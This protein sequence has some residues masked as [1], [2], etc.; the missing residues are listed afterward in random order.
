MRRL[1][2]AMAMRAPTWPRVASPGSRSSILELRGS[3]TTIVSTV[4]SSTPKTTSPSRALI[5]SSTGA[6]KAVGR[7]SVRSAALALIRILTSMSLIRKAT[8]GLADS[9]RSSRLRQSGTRR[10]PRCEEDG[11][12]RRSPTRPA[13]GAGHDL[14]VEHGPHLHGDPGDGEQSTFLRAPAP[15]RGRPHWRWADLSAPLGRSAIRRHGRVDRSGWAAALWTRSRRRAVVSDHGPAGDAG[16]RLSGQIVLGRPDS[17]AED[18]GV[19]TLEGG[20]DRRH[21]RARLSP[22]VT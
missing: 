11:C 8:D 7:G 10:Y 9:N 17:T 5:S 4:S 13:D 22:T 1:R 18:D 20:P 6:M 2:P 21:Q 15:L 3:S 14:S 16:H 12:A 19:G